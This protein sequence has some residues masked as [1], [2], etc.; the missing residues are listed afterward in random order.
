MTNDLESRFEEA[1]RTGLVKSVTDDSRECGPGVAFVAV[2]G[3]KADG[4]AF[5]EEATKKGCPFLVGEKSLSLPGYVQ[6][7]KSR[8]AL[9]WMASRIHGHPSRSMRMF[10]ITGTSGKTTCAFLLDAILREGGEKTGLVGTVQYRVGSETFPSTHTTPGIVALQSL[11]A[12]MR[13]A[14]CTSVVMETSSHA[15]EQGRVAGIAWD[16]MLFL[17]LSPEHLDYH[18]SMD[19]YFAA[20]RLL[21]TEYAKD[22]IAA[23]KKPVGVIEPSGEW[24]ERLLEECEG[25]PLQGFVVRRADPRKFKVSAGGIR[26]DVGGIPIRSPLVGNFNGSNIAAVASLAHAVGID[27]RA[28]SKGVESLHAVPGRMERVPNRRGAHVFVDYAH[29]PDALEKALLAVRALRDDAQ[30]GRVLTVFGCGG[31]RDRS[32]RPKMGGIAA[33]LSEQVFVTSDNPRT[34][35]PASIVSEI[36][37]GMKGTKNF[38]VI[39]DRKEAIR[40]ALEEAKSGDFVLIAGKGHEDYQIIGIKKFP[41]D[42]REVAKEFGLLP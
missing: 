16:A 27:A 9:G 3:S 34:E 30:Q 38:E 22:S 10:A 4:H 42:D 37:G 25:N 39:L 32:K 13:D 2:A 26:G 21:F 40:R 19:S 5:L 6:V 17:N 1:I 15:L 31:D 7:P 11:L 33:R 36:T 41:F 35:E 23:G 14:G 12:R 8:H 28:I 20:K 24:A 18:P 29:K